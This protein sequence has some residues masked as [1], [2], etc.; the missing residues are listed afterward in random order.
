MTKTISALLLLAA[1]G[2][3]PAAAIDGNL[4]GVYD[5]KFS[6]GGIGAGVQGKYKFES[7]LL[8]VQVDP[9]NVIFQIADIPGSGAGYVLTNAQKTTQGTI[10]AISC[11][12]GAADLNGTS[13]QASVKTKPSGAVTLKGTLVLFALDTASGN[14]CKF[15]AKRTSSGPVKLVGCS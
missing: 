9:G 14:V 4:G 3:L 2:A 11:N 1:L 8:M 12:L 6:C 7:E 13:L 15:S 5:A 10:T